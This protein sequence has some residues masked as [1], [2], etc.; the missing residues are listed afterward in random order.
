MGKNIII[1]CD[2]CDSIMGDD[3]YIKMVVSCY[4]VNTIGESDI[5]DQSV[6]KY[7]CGECHQEVLSEIL[8]RKRIH[9]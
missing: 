1:R 2:R 3:K 9:L 6:I 5:P 4:S 8:R 7:M